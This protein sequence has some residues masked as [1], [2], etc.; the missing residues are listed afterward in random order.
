MDHLYE[1]KISHLHDLINLSKIDGNEALNEVN[2]I[3]SVAD[4]LGISRVDLKKLKEKKSNII[5]TPPNDIYQ[6]M[7][8]YHRLIVLM[9]IDRI[10]AEE[11][12]KLCVNLG[13]K[14][15]LKREAIEEIIDKAIDTPRHVISVDEIENIFYRHYKNG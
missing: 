9:G 8:Q 10:I 2:F 15:N 13:L 1:E 11:E 6:V 14:M 5:F 7:M 3:N 4:R 12:K